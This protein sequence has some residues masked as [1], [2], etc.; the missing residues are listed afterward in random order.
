M[1]LVGQLQSLK[2]FALLVKGYEGLFFNL[3]NLFL[4]RL[5]CKGGLRHILVLSGAF[6]PVT[7]FGR[8]A[9]ID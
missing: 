4:N 8:N 1:L 5:F 2:Q 7:Q 6:E 3:E 9:K